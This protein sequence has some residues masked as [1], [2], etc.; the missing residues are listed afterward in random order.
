MNSLRPRI[1]INSITYD[2][3]DSNVLIQGTQQKNHLSFETSM[4][5]SFTELNVVLNVL[6]K[7]NPDISISDLFVEEKLSPDFTQYYFNA[8]PLANRS[9]MLNQYLLETAKKQIRA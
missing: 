5:I 4:M 3:Y 1:S 2:T 9:V 8:Q 7:S 6:Q